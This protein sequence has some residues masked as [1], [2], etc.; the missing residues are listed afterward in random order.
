VEAAGV[1][2]T[3]FG[4]NHF[5]SVVGA[6]PLALRLQINGQVF[7]YTGDTDW[8]P[9]LVPCG[10]GADLLIA[11]A[12]HYRS[13]YRFHLDFVTLK[14]HLPEIGAKRVILTHMNQDMINRAKNNSLGIEAADDGR[15]I[16]V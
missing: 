2:V 16:E 5:G 3:P 4:V 12:W 13:N 7:A 9:S 8:V 1:R 6:P 11:E 10:R 14:Q 15:T